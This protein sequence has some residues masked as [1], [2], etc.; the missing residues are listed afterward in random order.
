MSAN[1]LCIQDIRIW[2]NLF[3]PILIYYKTDVNT[4]GKTEDLSLPKID[5]QFS[6]AIDNQNRLCY[7]RFN[8][9]PY[10]FRKN[11]RSETQHF[12]G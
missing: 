2:N 9:V 12:R 8:E 1:C 5:K 4:F 6:V 10:G 7:N 11:Y 3:K